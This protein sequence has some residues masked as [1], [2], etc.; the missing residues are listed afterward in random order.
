MLNLNTQTLAAVAEQACRDAAEHGRW[1]VAIGRALVEL[2]TN[3]WIERGE[4]H[5]LIIGSP[6]GNLY[7][8]NGTCQCRA[9]AF[10]LP[11]WHRAASRLVRLH[12]EREAA[13]AALADH[14]IDVVD[15]SR[16]ARK[17]AAARIAAQFNA[18]LFA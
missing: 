18:E 2:E 17:I 1:L 12:D 5:G 9:Y 10:K 3:P 14:V 13:A 16:I 7:S 15:Q 11:C 8:A 4:L 6:S